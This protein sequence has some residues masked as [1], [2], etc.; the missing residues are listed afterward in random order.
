LTNIELKINERAPLIGEM[1]LIC[2]GTFLF[3]GGRICVAEKDEIGTCV[4]QEVRSKV[5]VLVLISQGLYSVNIGN[6]RKIN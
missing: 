2:R 6:L 1:F 5:F 4:G 3:A